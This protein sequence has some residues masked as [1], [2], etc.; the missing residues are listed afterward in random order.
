MATSTDQGVRGVLDVQQRLRQW[1]GILHV[2]P[3]RCPPGVSIDLHPPPGEVLWQCTR[4][5]LCRLKR[6]LAILLRPRI[7]RRGMQAAAM[8]FNDTVAPVAT[9]SLRAGSFCPQFKQYLSEPVP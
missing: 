9:T 3:A 5:L 1:I 6:I 4:L 8:V 7:I 2:L